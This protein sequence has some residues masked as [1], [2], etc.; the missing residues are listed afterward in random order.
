[1]AHD[2]PVLTRELDHAL[3]EVLAGRRRSRVVR[4]VQKHQLGLAR[5][6]FRNGLEVWQVVVELRQ[7][8]YV[9]HAACKAGPYRIDWIPGARHQDHVAGVHEG[10]RHVAD[11]F[12]RA[13]Q[14]EDLVGRIERD[15][16]APLV[17]VGDRLPEAQHPLVGRILVV[18]R[19]AHRLPHLLD[20]RR[21]GR[22]VRI[23]DAQID[24]VHPAGDGFLLHLI[25]RGEQI[26]R[27]GPDPARGLY[28]KSR[29][30]T[31][32]LSSCLSPPRGRF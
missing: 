12:L 26:R 19:I 1:M 4:I 9:R 22:Q 32:L 18:L 31:A 24:D 11:A 16:E 8:H 29:H 21:G 6:V 20:D 27:Q 7:R 30:E 25:D 5:H 17:P 14:R 3:E 13:N 2:D 10:Q 28:R 23:A 15:V